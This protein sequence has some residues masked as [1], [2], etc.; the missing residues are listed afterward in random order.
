MSVL[1]LLFDIFC[2]LL[3]SGWI[4][5]AQTVMLHCGMAGTASSCNIRHKHPAA[6]PGQ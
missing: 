3:R 1:F 6:T 5:A 2:T 4:L